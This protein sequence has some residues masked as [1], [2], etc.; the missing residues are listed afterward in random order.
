MSKRSGGLKRVASDSETED[1]AMQ[2]MHS[3][4]RVRNRPSLVVY[5]TRISIVTK[6]NLDYQQVCTDLCG[7]TKQ[8]SHYMRG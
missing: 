5:T 2:L 4:K 3:H 1:G 6:G 7:Q 8:R